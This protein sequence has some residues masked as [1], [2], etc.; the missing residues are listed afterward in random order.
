[1]AAQACFQATMPASAAAW[2]P[3]GWMSPYQLL[4]ASSTLG[5]RGS[6]VPT[7]SYC[8]S[9]PG[10]R[11]TLAI[12]STA[13]TTMAPSATLRTGTDSVFSK[14]ATRAQMRVRPYTEGSRWGGGGGRDHTR[15]VLGA[16]PKRCVDPKAMHAGTQGCIALHFRNAAHTQLH[17]GPPHL[18]HALAAHRRPPGWSPAPPAAPPLGPGWWAP[19][20]EQSAAAQRWPR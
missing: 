11:S 4:L 18:C 9:R 19:A 14:T 13:S 7:G 1:M 15:Q 5:R 17:A 3:S 6:R 2:L 20:S 10:R 16:M 12:D 8:G